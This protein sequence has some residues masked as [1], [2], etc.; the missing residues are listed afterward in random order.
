M[1]QVTFDELSRLGGER[2][3]GAEFETAM[4]DCSPGAF[5]SSASRATRRAERG[6]LADLGDARPRDARRSGWCC[7]RRRRREARPA[8]RASDRHAHD[9]IHTPGRR[10]CVSD[11]NRGGRFAR[12]QLPRR[13]ARPLYSAA[14]S[15]TWRCG[16]APDSR[17]ALTAAAVGPTRT[18]EPADA[19]PTIARRS[20]GRWRRAARRRSRRPPR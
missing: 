5:A 6:R 1:I 17:Q 14:D 9:A 8:S 4:L 3:I 2:I 19:A 20:R 15:N 12:S 11:V 7:R 13:C 18:A 16:E 10:V